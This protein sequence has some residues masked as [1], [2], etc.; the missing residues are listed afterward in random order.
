MN[1]LSDQN[2]N[3]P[4]CNGS[5]SVCFTAKVLGKYDVPYVY[6]GSC[7]LLQ[8]RSPYWLEEAYQSGKLPHRIAPHCYG[9]FEDDVVDVLIL[10]LCDGIL[11]EWDE[12]NDKER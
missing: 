4:V 7:G 3:C 11:S 5:R 9:A 8:A 1:H 2:L 6:C 10:E 12:L